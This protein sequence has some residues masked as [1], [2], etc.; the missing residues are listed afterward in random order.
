MASVLKAINPPHLYYN[1]PY[2][3]LGVQCL[4]PDNSD[5]IFWSGRKNYGYLNSSLTR[6][7]ISTNS[8]IY[9][10]SSLNYCFYNGTAISMNVYNFPSFRKIRSSPTLFAPAILSYDEP[11]FDSVMFTVY[12]IL[13]IIYYIQYLKPNMV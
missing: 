10:Y 5:N 6:S 13:Y 11:L 2:L 3:G 1:F 9:N 12:Q 7:I 8:N 4:Y